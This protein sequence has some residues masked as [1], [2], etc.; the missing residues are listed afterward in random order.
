V[1]VKAGVESVKDNHGKVAPG[2]T[3]NG[4]SATVED[5]TQISL[6]RFRVGIAGLKA[7]IEELKSWRRRPD[8]EIAEELL[9]RLKPQNYIPPSAED[10]YRQAFLRE[11]KKTLGEKVEEEPRGLSIKILGPGCP[12]CDRL[13]QTAMTVLAELGLP[14]E[15]EHVRDVREIAALGIMG[16]PALLINGEVKA[17]GTAPTRAMLKKWLMAV[18]S[19]KQ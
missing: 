17:V 19:Q 16:T 9:V 10:E 15:V 13:E 3:D 5:L 12:V 14:A 7:A 18:S 8:A 2:D 11:F 1:R 6:S 4:K